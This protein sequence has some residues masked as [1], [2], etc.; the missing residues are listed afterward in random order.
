MGVELIPQRYSISYSISGSG[1]TAN[2]NIDMDKIRA[3]RLLPA[4]GMREAFSN[5]FSFWT[6]KV[7]H[8]VWED[9]QDPAGR[10]TRSPEKVLILFE[11]LERAGWSV[12]LR[13]FVRHY[14]GAR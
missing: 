5:R 1:V 2:A 13:D 3:D 9:F 4:F 7:V 6:N 14:W 11:K 12:D 10:P 8:L